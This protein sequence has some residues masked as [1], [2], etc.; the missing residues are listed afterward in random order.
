MPFLFWTSRGF[1]VVDVNYGGSTGYGRSYRE[2]L[3]GQWGLVDVDDCVNA[4]L[5][6]VKEGLADP[7]RLA[8]EGGSAGGFTTL[9]SLAFRKVFKAGADY[10]GVSDLEGLALDTHKFESRYLDRLVGPYPADRETYLTRSPIHSV[11]T[12]ECPIIIFQGAED[13]IVPPSQSEKM[14]KSLRDRGIPTAYFLYEGEQH[15]FRRSANIRHSLE[16]ELYFF[17][18]VLGFTLGEELE[19][20]AIDNL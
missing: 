2:R 16:A 8:I 4:A 19:P 10:F 11:E 20:I 5:Y 12:I 9:A 18:K 7:D 3:N 17:S 13:A 1:A 6:C 14:Y 15:G